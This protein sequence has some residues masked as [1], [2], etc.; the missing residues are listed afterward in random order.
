MPTSRYLI[1]TRSITCRNCS[2]S[3]TSPEVMEVADS[4]SFGITSKKTKDILFNVPIGTSSLRCEEVPVCH[5]CFSTFPSHQLPPPIE[6]ASFAET[7]Y[8]KLSSSSNTEGKKTDNKPA[9]K[10]NYSDFDLEL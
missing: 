6:E 2:A 9:Q 5:L 1:Y 7:V 4:K 10:I 8:K 3:F